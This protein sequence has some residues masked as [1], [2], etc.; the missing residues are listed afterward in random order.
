MHITDAL[1]RAAHNYPHGGIEALAT[2]MGISPSSLAHKVSP[3][4]PTAHCSPGEMAQI[5][6]LTGDHSA[7][8]ALAD[9]LGYLLVPLPQGEAGAGFAQEL[10]TT[11]H[12]FG[13]F[14]AEASQD[15]ADGRVTDT[16]LRRIER[17]GAQALAAIQQ[18]MALA[19]R[20]NLEAKPA[21][22]R[23]VQSAA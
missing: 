15:L 22:L 11:V 10:A 12:E 13:Q 5:M 14:I 20:I 19:G 23:A 16:E 2:R 6:E 17:E 18:L 3:T 4:Y 7:L 1:Y 21:A 8:Q 9:R